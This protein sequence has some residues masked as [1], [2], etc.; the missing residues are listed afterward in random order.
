MFSVGR[1]K[2][3]EKI[4]AWEVLSRTPFDYTFCK[5]EKEW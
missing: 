5:C 1:L 2:K 3:I 4:V